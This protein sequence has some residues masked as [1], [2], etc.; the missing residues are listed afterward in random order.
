MRDFGRLARTLQ[1]VFR[2]PPAGVREVRQVFAI[3]RILEGETADLVCA[4]LGL[5]R[6]GVVRLLKEL[7]S[8]GLAGFL[9]H[10]E[11][12]TAQLLEQ[13]RLGIAQMLLGA[14]AER[15]FEELSDEITGGGVLR[16]ED[17][18][19]SRTDTDYRLLNGQGNP[20]CRLNIKFHGTLFR[21]SRRYVGLE[22]Q[23]CFAL[24]TYKINNA[25][26]R[27]EEER[28]PYVFLVLSIP[29]LNAGQVAKLIPDDYVWTLS[30]LQGRRIVEEAIVGRLRAPDHLKRFLP[31]FKRMP[32]GQF[33]IISAKKAYNLLRDKLFERIH[34]L[35]LKGFTSRFRNAEVDMHFSLSKELT[36]VRTFLELLIKESPQKFAVRLYIGD[37]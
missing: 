20:I 19:P 16:V 3:R 31:I 32:E 37:Y 13:R 8:K 17:H 6:H 15:R 4:E 30:V 29:E 28:L 24:A 10:E 35:S 7:R 34:A 23:D 33:R 21:D 36:P 27:Q 12:T 25:L 2:D 1:D 18:R 14:L 22:P 11:R 5:Q 26:K 9:P